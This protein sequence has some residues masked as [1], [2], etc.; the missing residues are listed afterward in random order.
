MRISNIRN[1]LTETNRDIRVRSIY[2]LQRDATEETIDALMVLC[3]DSDYKVRATAA[4]VLGWVAIRDKKKLHDATRILIG[5]A[6]DEKSIRVRSAAIA[7]LGARY[8]SR[9]VCHRMIFPVLV[10]ASQDAK[11]SIRLAVSGALSSIENKKSIP[12][13]ENLLSDSN[14]DVR[15]WTAF[16]LEWTRLD[17]EGIRNA[18]VNM[19]EDEFDDARCEAIWA[20]ARFKD[21]RVLPVL[22]HE[23]QKKVVGLRMIKA[24]GD[25][26]DASLLPELKQLVNDFKGDGDE[27]ERIA[28][29][30]YKRLMRKTR[31]RNHKKK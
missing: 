2:E 27:G 18:L 23:L 7:A 10:Q 30:Q 17:S 16:F 13:V 26:G 25:L 4:T 9:P 21:S 19:L 1:L 11:N 29:K 5:L 31:I 6:V 22:R 3:S 24:A 28:Q 14:R 12:L 15:N 20:L 8:D